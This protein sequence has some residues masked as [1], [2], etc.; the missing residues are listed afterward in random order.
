MPSLKVSVFM[1]SA[2]LSLFWPYLNRHAPVVQNTVAPS[3]PTGLGSG[4]SCSWLGSGHVAAKRSGA[5]WYLTKYVAC[6]AAKAS[7][8]GVL[9]TPASVV[10]V[11]ST[12]GA[13][14]AFIP[15][16]ISNAWRAGSLLK[17]KKPSG[18]YTLVLMLW[19][20]GASDRQPWA[21]KTTP[22][23]AAFVSTTCWLSARSWSHVVGMSVIP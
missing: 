6:C 11:F 13:D 16:M 9:F 18:V 14:K 23:G 5:F 20:I 1:Y 17:S 22:Y 12:F 10:P 4:P 21:S 15:F 7:S 3:P 8:S 2:A 19:V